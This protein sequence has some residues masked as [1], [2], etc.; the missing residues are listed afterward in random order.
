MKNKKTRDSA[1]MTLT[2]LPRNRSGSHVGM[3]ISFVI[4]ITFMVFLYSIVKPAINTGGDKQ[5][6]LASLEMQIIKNISTNLTSAS[7]QLNS[8]TN[9]NQNCIMLSNFL[10]FSE[11]ST[12]NMLIKNGANSIQQAYSNY[13]NQFPDIMINRQSKNDLF[14]K[15][16]YSSEF[17]QLGS[18]AISC[19]SLTDYNIGSVTTGGYV[20]ETEINRFI[21]LYNSSSYNSLK[22]YFKLPPGN[23]FGFGFIKS[24]GT[25]VDVGK[26]PQSVSVYTD[27]VP[28]QYV[29]SNANI[30]SG[31]INIKVW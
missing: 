16:Y 7:V 21:N 17:N 11:L 1:R 22:E 2:L 9:P 24:D 30:L 6:I 12:P 15:V 8:G 27:Q 19:K 10:V 18:T 29:D 5:A 28:V 3:I 20:F 25:K 4:F 14:F 23:E 26:A 31:F 13:N